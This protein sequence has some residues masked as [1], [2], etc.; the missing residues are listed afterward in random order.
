[1]GTFTLQ[2]YE[3]LEMPTF[4]EEYWKALLEETHIPEE[5]EE[6]VPFWIFDGDDLLPG[7]PVKRLVRTEPRKEKE[8]ERYEK[9]QRRA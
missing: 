1:M 8:G 6:Q 7:R 3:Q 9:R 5:P 2:E 4:D